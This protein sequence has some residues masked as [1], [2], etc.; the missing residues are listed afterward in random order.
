MLRKVSFILVIV[1][2]MI[3]LIFLNLNVK[4]IKN[5]EDLKSLN[6]N[7]KVSLEGFVSNERVAGSLKIFT[8]NGIDVVC[9]CS[10]NYKGTEVRVVGLVSEFNSKRQVMVLEIINKRKV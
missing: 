5:Y 8:I 9:E 1:G 6:I 4:D 3:L 10:E 2:L 7:Q